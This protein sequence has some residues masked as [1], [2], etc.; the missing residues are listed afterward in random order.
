MSR[1]VL[2]SMVAITAATLILAGT[3]GAHASTS[4]DD[5]MA[6]R[7]LSDLA[8]AEEGGSAYFIVSRAD[9][10]ADRFEQ[11]VWVVDGSAEPEFVRSVPPE[12]SSLRLSGTGELAFLL[13]TSKGTQIYLQH[14]DGRLLGPISDAPLGVGA[15]RHTPNSVLFTT[16]GDCDGARTLAGP[17]GCLVRD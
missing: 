10:G 9:E 7:S 13:P 14:G 3:G 17:K 5:V 16:V 12:A 1:P 15:F 11:E 4:V 2:R 8:W 6:I